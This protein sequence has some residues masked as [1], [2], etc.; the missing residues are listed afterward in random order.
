M[1]VDT[2]LQLLV[3]VGPPALVAPVTLPILLIVLAHHRL[4]DS[5]NISI[6]ILHK[7]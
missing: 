5:T 7:I 4:R 6:S 2:F 3:T 1:V